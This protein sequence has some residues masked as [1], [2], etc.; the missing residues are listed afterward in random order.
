MTR[1]EAKD[2]FRN[3]KDAYGR[4]RGIMKKIDM[5]FDSFEKVK[6]KV[7]SAFK[8]RTRLERLTTEALNEIKNIK[9]HATKEEIERLNFETFNPKRASFCIYGQMT[10]S[11][12][13]DR[14]IELGPK[15]YQSSYVGFTEGKIDLRSGKA[16]TALEKYVAYADPQINR[17]IIDFI[18]GERTSLGLPYLKL[19]VSEQEG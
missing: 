5:I 16:F 8:L 15:C 10:G 18:K 11:C 1:E 14:A 17:N 9:K 13:S 12:Y 7:K 2:L 6:P 4:P 19:I 3:D